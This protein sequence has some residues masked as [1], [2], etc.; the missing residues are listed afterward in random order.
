M[1][2]QRTPPRPYGLIRRSLQQAR[3]VQVC[4]QSSRTLKTE[5]LQRC[6]IARPGERYVIDCTVRCTAP[7]SDCW[8]TVCRYT[9][10]APSDAPA[11]AQLHIQYA[12]AYAKPMSAMMRRVLEPA[13]ESGLAKNFA[14][15]IDVLRTYAPLTDASVPLAAAAAAAVPLPPH[16]APAH[17]P[18]TQRR[19]VALL[20]ALGAR[21][22][23]PPMWR[24]FVDEHLLDV[25]LPSAQILLAAVAVDVPDAG[26][27]GA[28]GIAAVLSTLLVGVLL[29]AILSAWHAVGGAC[30]RS[31]GLA[32]RLC[33]QLYALLDLPKSVAGLVV[34]I[35]II[36]LVRSLVTGVAKVRSPPRPRVFPVRHQCHW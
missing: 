36:L 33:A 6:L 18:A 35:G 10:A 16:A 5:E 21:R 27:S 22:R 9:L 1:P 4:F 17:A 19:V 34:A 14:Q 12:M 8:R 31:T 25:C 3:N 20:T 26:G 29:Q 2:L 11:S 28:R 15:F 7:Y 30:G 24:V 32:G 13:A 23:M